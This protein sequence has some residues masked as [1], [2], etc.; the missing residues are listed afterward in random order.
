MRA[1]HF[2]IDAITSLYLLVLL[3]RLVLPFF[4]AN[5]RNPIAQGIYRITSPL[6]VPLRRVIPPIGKVDTATVIVAFV[7]QYAAVLLIVAMYGLAVSMGPLA[8]TALIKLAVL[9]VQ[10]FAYACVIRVILGWVA[11]GQYNPAT[12]LIHSLTE[13]VLTPF[14]RIIPPIGGLDISPVF[15]II[16]LF[17]VAILVGDFRPYP[18]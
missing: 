12:E 3:L 14:R 15:A 6:V 4:G 11:P 18:V 5:F 8:L 10:L 7:I 2:I 16:G 1:V 9:F 13:P 17:A